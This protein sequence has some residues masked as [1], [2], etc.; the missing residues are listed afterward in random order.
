MCWLDCSL[1][2][3]PLNYDDTTIPSTFQLWG[4]PARVELRLSLEWSATPLTWWFRADCYWGGPASNWPIILVA[5][6]AHT[7]NLVTLG[8]ASTGSWVVRDP[9]MIYNKMQ[10][11]FVVPVSPIGSSTYRTPLNYPSNRSTVDH[12]YC[13]KC[14]SRCSIVCCCTLAAIDIDSWVAVEWS[15]WLTFLFLAAYLRI[16]WDMQPSCYIR[17]RWNSKSFE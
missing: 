15:D 12:T 13:P 16:W 11:Y 7:I 6:A 5:R 17:M 3:M 1:S 10:P 8:I 4:D 9:T 14:P 2:C